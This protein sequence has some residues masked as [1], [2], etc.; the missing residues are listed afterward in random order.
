MTVLFDRRRWRRWTRLPSTEKIEWLVTKLDAVTEKEHFKACGVLDWFKA[1]LIGTGVAVDG[2]AEEQINVWLTLL[3]L[4]W[5]E[6]SAGQDVFDKGFATGPSKELLELN[7]ALGKWL[8]SPDGFYE[9]ILLHPLIDQRVPVKKPK[10]KIIYLE[11]TSMAAE[12]FNASTELIESLEARKKKTRGE[13]AETRLQLELY[14]LYMDV[15]GRKRLSDT[16]PAR[17]FVKA[18]ATEIG[19]IVK[20]RGFADLISKA[21]LRDQGLTRSRRAC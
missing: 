13:S 21:A 6:Y 20:E 2:V 15:T 19:V 11:Q 8:N 17:Q 12:L 18:F 3:L 5:I 16:G 1:T 14:Y 4:V 7:A 9:Q 10:S